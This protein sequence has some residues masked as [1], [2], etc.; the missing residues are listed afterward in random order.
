MRRKFRKRSAVG[1]DA[2]ADLPIADEGVITETTIYLTI[3]AAFE[4]AIGSKPWFSQYSPGTQRTL[5]YAFYT[6][7][8]E[9]LRT[10]AFR[11]NAEQ[12]D[13]VFKDF[14]AE[15]LAYDLE[16]QAAAKSADAELH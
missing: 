6:A 4:D 9:T 12:S 3:A 10:I 2:P 13:A 7:A 16:L 8:A 11:M 14:D 1:I 15:L 5:K